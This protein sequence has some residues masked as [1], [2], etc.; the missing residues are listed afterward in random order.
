MSAKT[1]GLHRIAPI[2]ESY[3]GDTRLY[4]RS[5]GHVAQGS[6]MPRF[7]ESFLPWALELGCMKLM[8]I[9]IPY[10]PYHIP[11]TLY[12]IPYVLYQIPQ[13]T[14]YIPD[15]YV[16]MFVG[17]PTFTKGLP[18]ELNPAFPSTGSRY[19]LQ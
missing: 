8:S 6:C 5:V 13:T 7:M 19:S 11:R 17:P 4:V 9:Y 16:Y 10:T 14:Y 12:N 18:V 15:P 3:L 1:K 2:E